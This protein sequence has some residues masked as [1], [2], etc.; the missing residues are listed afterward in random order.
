MEENSY[1]INTQYGEDSPVIQQKDRVTEMV[2]NH[3]EYMENVLNAGVDVT[4]MYDYDEVM[5]MRKWDYTSAAVHFYGH[6][7][8]DAS[9]KGVTLE[10]C[11][12]RQQ[13]F[14]LK[15]FGE[16]D[17]SKGLLEH[18]KK[19]VIEIYEDASD[20]EEWVDIIILAMEGAWR[21]GA[22]PKDIADIF[23]LKMSKNERR[24]WP[25]IGSIEPGKPIEHL[26]AV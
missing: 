1:I 12:K 5:E 25:A 20:T 14:A 21:T 11:I 19:E 17:H 13:T 4:R 16:G 15:A 23:N 8:E 18:I 24:A 2:D 22:S 9:N 6:G 10:D 26:R 7:F 3:W